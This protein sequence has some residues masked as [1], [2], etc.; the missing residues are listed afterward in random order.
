MSAV[1]DTVVVGGP[2]DNY[3]GG[4][5]G[6][7]WVWTRSGS[8]WTQQGNK[9][10]GTGPGGGY[11][12]GV[13]V[14]ISADGNTVLVGGPG[15]S[16]G[17]GAAW[18]WKR[19]D[20][21]W[22]QLG[23]RI[24]GTGWK[25]RAT[26]GQ[27]VALS[28]GGNTAI[29]GGPLDFGGPGDQDVVGAAWTF[30]SAA[31]LLFHQQPSTAVAGRSMAPTVTIQLLDAS[32]D[33]VALPGVT[34]TLS[35]TNGTGTLLGTSSQTSDPSGLATFDNLSIDL[36]GSKQL[37]ATSAGLAPAVSDP[38]S[39]TAAEASAIVVTGGGTQSTPVGTAFP[40]PLQVTVTDAFGNAVS[41]ARV[42]FQSPTGQPGALLGNGGIAIT[43]ASGRASIS[44]TANG[45]PGGP[46]V[47]TATVDTLRAVPFSLTN[48][49]DTPIA[50]PALD[51]AG[52]IGLAI[53]L[54]AVGTLA[55]KG[56]FKTR[57]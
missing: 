46:Y 13:A 41:G 32:G 18:A 44:A 30:V 33:P 11:L 17:I 50:I 28:A 47:V 6:A 49:A 57:C 22:T 53:S 19:R 1:G 31:R 15:T 4:F 21:S 52:L 10:V 36:A 25:Q 43:G 56:V 42:A 5:V 54:A 24:V 9:L 37:T 14:A 45:L 34:V 8:V 38:F 16:G 26:Q 55:A 12:Q 51:Q 2:Y 29:I 48:L 23:E 7:A 3:S 40:E 20:G 27:S 35:L 39:I